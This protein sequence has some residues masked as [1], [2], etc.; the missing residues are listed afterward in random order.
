[1][2]STTDATPV[3]ATPT[4]ESF[5]VE[6]PHTRRSD[7]E[8]VEYLSLTILAVDDLEFMLRMQRLGRQLK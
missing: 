5:E 2:A 7:R 1:M 3:A 8:F 6:E 4:P